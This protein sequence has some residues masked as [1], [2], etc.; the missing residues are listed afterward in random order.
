MALLIDS[1]IVIYSISEKFHYLRALLVSKDC[2]VSEISRVE[3]LGYHGLNNTDEKYFLDVFDYVSIITPSQTIFDE[4]IE[5]RRRYNLKLG[6]SIIAA[7]VIAH[8]L[9]LYTH[10]IKDFTRVGGINCID[11]IRP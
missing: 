9:D 11:P 6:D 10:N 2:F 1:N 7:T 8:K 3:V 5:V 4:A